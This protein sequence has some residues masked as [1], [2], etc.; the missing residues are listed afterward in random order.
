LQQVTVEALLHFIRS[1]IL[2]IDV[3]GV[4]IESGRRKADKALA[5]LCVENDRG[6]F[7]FGKDETLTLRESLE[8]VRSI[9]TLKPFSKISF[10]QL[11]IITAF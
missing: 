1:N 9:Q 11:Q 7:Y 8:R 5:H 6:S 3:E 4:E 10:L 2:N